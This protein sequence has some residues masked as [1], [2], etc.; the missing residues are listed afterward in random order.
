VGNEDAT[1][2]SLSLRKK[3]ATGLA[4]VGVGIVLYLAAWPVP[5]DP[6]AWE[7]PANAG[8][9]GAHAVNDRLARIERLSIRDHHGPESVAI[10]EAGRIYASTHEGAIVR[11]APDG[12]KPQRWARTGGRPLGLDFDAA[13]NLLVADAYRGLLSIS[14]DAHVE[15]L[16]TVADGIPIR[17]ADDVA[18][19]R[20]G[21]IYFSDASTKFGAQKWG[22]VSPASMLDILEHGG[23]GR[24]LVYDPR[25][26][27]ATTLLDGLNFANG[28]A[29]SHDQQFV[30]VNETGS[31]RIVRVWI[32][33]PDA[34]ASEPFVEAL[35]GFPDNV[36][37]GHEGRFWVGMFAPRNP[38]VDAL[39][40]KPFLRKVVLRIPKALRPEAAHYGHV[41]AFDDQGRVVADLQDPAGRYP[42]TTSALE[43]DAH[44][45]IG[46]LVAPELARISRR[47]VGL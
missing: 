6:E 42:M 4:V 20:D 30:L 13:G 3:L 40:D 26:E 29:V 16:A 5:V 47:D 37:T 24:L 41:V 7:A 39:A 45:Y 32:E 18:A 21:R 33:G 9:T 15:T 38:V 10:D 23:H 36:T 43:T 1:L 19:A 11:L 14:A 28:V 34:G 17:F 12:S 31:Y 35:P 46:S 25:T 22:G 8:Y 44:V 27:E 2:A